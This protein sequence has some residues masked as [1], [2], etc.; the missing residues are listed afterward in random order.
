[1]EDP[2]PV[3]AHPTLIVEDVVD[4]DPHPTLVA[5]DAE[6]PP[7]PVAPP[8]PAAPSIVMLHDAE[9]P[10][11]IFRTHHDASPLPLPPRPPGA[12]EPFVGSDDALFPAGPPAT[13][14]QTHAHQTWPEPSASETS[15]EWQLL[16]DSVLAD[17][18]GSLM[19]ELA[20]S[21]P[22]EEALISDVRT[23]QSS[24][25]EERAPAEPTLELPAIVPAQREEAMVRATADAASS[26]EEKAILSGSLDALADLVTREAALSRAAEWPMEAEAEE[27][28]HTEHTLEA[29]DRAEATQPLDSLQADLTSPTMTIETVGIFEDTATHTSVEIPSA[30]PTDD[31]IT[32][33]PP[34]EP[35]DFRPLDAALQAPPFRPT[36]EEAPKPPEE[37]ADSGSWPAYWANSDQEGAG[38]PAEELEDSTLGPALALSAV[39]LV[40]L[41]SVLGV[42]GWNLYAASVPA[43][44]S[45]P[46]NLASTQAPAEPADALPGGLVRILRRGPGGDGATKFAEATTAYDAGEYSRALELFMAAHTLEP[47]GATAYNVAAV[48]QALG[49]TGPAQEWYQKVSASSPDHARLAAE[50]LAALQA[51]DGSD[52]RSTP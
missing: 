35:P 40:M 23:P 11:D 51:L 26:L 44:T 43:P 17:L 18:D 15:D 13:S 12:D 1:V 42:L 34:V 48:Y 52:H 22:E 21:L 37:D 27:H 41:L 39:G 49:A 16:D 46:R 10:D 9:L 5:E 30:P 8:A 33:R 14:R 36:E 2:L 32:P 25:R 19:D 47:D 4:D 38:A 24:N 7:L 29:L 20:A 6:E 50:R 45:A 3:E 28:E 31:E